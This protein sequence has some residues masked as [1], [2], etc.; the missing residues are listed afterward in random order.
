MGHAAD[1]RKRVCQLRPVP[2]HARQILERSLLVPRH[3][4]MQAPPVL[5]AGSDIQNLRLCL[6]RRA[7]GLSLN[8]QSAGCGWPSQPLTSD[9]HLPVRFGVVESLENITRIVRFNAINLHV[10]LHRGELRRD[11]LLLIVVWIW[12]LGENCRHLPR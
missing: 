9:Q 1:L 10:L 7:F 3:V 2:L 12:I 5:R 6:G 4:L 8:L 11:I